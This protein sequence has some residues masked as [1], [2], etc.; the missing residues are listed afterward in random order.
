MTEERYAIN[1]R[2]DKA[3]NDA[4]NK[5]AKSFGI[6]SVSAIVKRILRIHFGLI[7]QDKENDD[8]E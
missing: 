5:E 6:D 1:V 4:L 2:L 3:L 8:A 7:G